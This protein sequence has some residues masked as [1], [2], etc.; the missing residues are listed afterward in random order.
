MGISYKV[1][2]G[3]DPVSSMGGGML[4]SFQPVPGTIHLDS[5]ANMEVTLCCQQHWPTG[6]GGIVLLCHE[7][8]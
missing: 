5:S 1:G 6:L 8:I 4:S 3:H 7:A 2:F